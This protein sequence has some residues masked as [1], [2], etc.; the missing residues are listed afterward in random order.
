MLKSVT[1]I[2]PKVKP[3]FALEKR[4]RCVFS[5]DYKLSILQQ[6]DTCQHG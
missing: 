1:I 5:T 4:T 3:N 6:T 2:D